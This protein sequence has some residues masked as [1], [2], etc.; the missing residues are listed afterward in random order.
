MQ[1]PHLARFFRVITFDPRGI[2]GG[3]RTEDPAAFELDRVVDYGV[4]L[5]DHLGVAAASVVGLSMG[6]AYG[7][8][9][10][11]RYPAR[12]ATRGDRDRPTGMGVRGRSG[13]FHPPT[14]DAGVCS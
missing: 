3:E 6:G 11:G 1:V 14:N 12:H 4:A 10:A 8:W 7:L 9:M 5:L 13:V 2:G